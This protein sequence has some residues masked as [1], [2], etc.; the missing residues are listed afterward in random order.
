V[1]SLSSVLYDP[2]CQI[3]DL[4]LLRRFH[5]ANQPA[6]AR[7]R[8]GEYEPDRRTSYWVEQAPPFRCP[9]NACTLGAELGDG[10][11]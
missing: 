3:G 1:D 7:R 9:L 4:V 5:P 11:V 10:E 2:A 6:P 8:F